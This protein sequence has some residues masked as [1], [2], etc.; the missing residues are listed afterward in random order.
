MLCL[1][2]LKT[3]GNMKA[4][5]SHPNHITTARYDSKITAIDENVIAHIIWKL[6]T[7][8][9][10]EVFKT[11]DSE[12]IELNFKDIDKNRNYEQIFKS[13][14]KLIDTK[15]YYEKNIPPKNKIQRTISQFISGVR[16][17][18]NNRSIIIEIP[19]F[20]LEYLSYLN[21]GY[22]KIELD[23]Y[24]RLKSVYSKR[25]YKLCKQYCDTGGFRW[26]ETQLREVLDIK[27]SHRRLSDLKKRTLD[28][29]SNELKD[30]CLLYFNYS[31]ETQNNQRQFVFKIKSSVSKK[32]TEKTIQAIANIGIKKDSTIFIY[33]FLL[34]FFPSHIN[35]KAISITK[36]I[37]QKDCVNKIEKRFKHLKMEIENGKKNKMSA[38]NLLVNV[39]LPEYDIIKKDNSS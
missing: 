27:N 25:L 38:K 13:L 26:T 7:H 14:N 28:K 8:T 23:Y 21:G 24:F 22:S 37:I 30:K 12:K 29:A 20:T 31:I 15:I 35:D 17:T 2:L 19:S 32:T 9:H 1:T 5:I 16:K 18:E 10:F 6:R 36:K 3:E 34:Y 11:F 39:I 4:I 33:Q